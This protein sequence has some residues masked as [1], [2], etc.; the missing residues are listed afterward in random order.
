MFEKKA[1][2]QQ[3]TDHIAITTECF[4]DILSCIRRLE[5]RI[6]SLDAKRN[7][8]RNPTKKDKKKDKR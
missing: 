4:K 7:W 8:K 6:A 3:L 5:E 2:E 1:T